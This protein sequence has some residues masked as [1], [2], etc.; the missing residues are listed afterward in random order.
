MRDN[1]GLKLPN[2]ENVTLPEGKFTKY[3]LGGENE[4]GLAKGRAF[5]SRLGYDINNWRDLQKELQRGAAQYPA[6]LKSAD[7]FGVRYEQKMVLYGRKGMPANVV[8]GWIQKPDGAV[9]MT[10]AYIKEVK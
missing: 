5:T 9:S 8:V 1:P 10:S 4:T 3:L 2:A 6:I 7:K